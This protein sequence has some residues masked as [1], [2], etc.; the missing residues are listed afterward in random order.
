MARPT[1]LAE[2]RTV[3]YVLEDNRDDPEADRTTFSLRS[4]RG[5][6][7]DRVEE[8]A[9]ENAVIKTGG[10][11]EAELRLSDYLA[12]CKLAAEFGL[13]GWENLQRADGTVVEFPGM[14]SRAVQCLPGEVLQEL[15]EEIRR[16]S[17]LSQAD[18]KN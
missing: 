3:P 17:E 4:L 6:Q 14:G 10:S 5:T 16:L 8:R 2:L 18:R 1:A 12:S 7:R 11:G 13:V 9:L 15:G